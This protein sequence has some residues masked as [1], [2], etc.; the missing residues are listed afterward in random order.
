[1]LGEDDKPVMGGFSG[2][3]CKFG[4]FGQTIGVYVNST[5]VKC[6]T[7]AVQEDPDDIYME[8]VTFSLSMNGFDF[9]DDTSDLEFI[10]NGSGSAFGLAY[11]VVAIIL[12][13]ILI[14]A[15]IYCT[16]FVYL[17]ADVYNER[18]SIDANI[19]N[20]GFNQESKRVPAGN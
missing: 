2:I 12:T 5:L 8:T 20:S 19:R 7:P 13:G 15:C 6:S 17:Q 4:S 16:M 10:F 3:K 14:G 1:M 18:G 11:M 9:D